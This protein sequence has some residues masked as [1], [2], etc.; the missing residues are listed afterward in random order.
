MLGFCTEC[1][2]GLM[3]GACPKGHLQPHA[4]SGGVARYSGQAIIGVL[5]KAPVSG[6][7]FGAAIEYVIYL[8]L[9][10]IG[11]LTQI[12][13]V[14]TVPLLILFL[15]F[16][17]ADGGRFSLGK[18]IGSLRVVDTRTG[19]PAT[20]RQG[21]MRNAYYIGF[22]LLS[23]V[24][25]LNFVSSGIFGLVGALDLLMVLASPRGQRLGD[26]L[27]N[28]QVVVERLR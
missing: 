22:A 15:C 8:I 14:V 17:D 23:V 3:N 7:L 24:P 1:G 18:R 10:A 16:R 2:G 6:R 19:Q 20:T 11:D 13:V 9:L 25:V 12:G 4:V 27:A 21:L 26:Q 28:T 5:P